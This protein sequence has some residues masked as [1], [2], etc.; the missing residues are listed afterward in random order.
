MLIFVYERT[1]AGGA[2]FTGAFALVWIVSIFVDALRLTDGET[3]MKYPTPPTAKPDFTVPAIELHGLPVE[4]LG[5]NPLTDEPVFRVDLTD[6]ELR[7][8]VNAA[9]WE[10]FSEQLWEKAK[11]VV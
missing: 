9:I 5:V 1:S 6:K 8:R 11:G 2:V 7:E 10:E 4:I 3:A